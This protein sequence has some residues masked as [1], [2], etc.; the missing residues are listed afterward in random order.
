MATRPSKRF[1]SCKLRVRSI[2]TSGKKITKNIALKASNHISNELKST[3]V[4]SSA[5]ERHN[6]YEF[7]EGEGYCDEEHT[8]ATN[9]QNRREKEFQG[10]QTI[11]ESLLNGR[12]VEEVFL[13][14]EKG[15]EC[16]VIGVE[17]R[18]NECAHEKYFCKGCADSTHET[19]NYFHVLERFKDGYTLPYFP[20]HSILAARHQ[21][22]CHSAQARN[23]ICIDQYGRQHQK[24]I[25]FFECEK[26]SITLIRLKLWPGSATRPSLAFHFKMMEL[27]ETLLLECHV[28]LRKFCDA[29]KIWTKCS[30]L[31]LWIKN[32]YSTLNSNSFDEFRYH[33]HLLR[34][35]YPLVN[36]HVPGGY[37][38]PL[39]PKPDEAGTLIESM[40]AYF[41]LVR[42]KTSG[43]VQFLSR[44]N[45][46]LFHNQEEVDSFVDNYT[47]SAEQAK[48]PF[49]VKDCHEF[50]AGEVND[51]IRSKGRNKLFDEK[52]VFGCVCRHD[53]PKGFMNIKHGERIGYSVFSVKHQLSNSNENTTIKIMYDIACTLKAHLMKNGKHDFVKRADYSIPVFHCYGHKSLCQIQFNPRRK[54]GYGLTDGEGV[55]RLWSF[56]RGFS[57]MTK[58]MSS[59]R[60]LDILTD[61]LLHYSSRRLEQFDTWMKEE[62]Q[63]I[64]EKN[65]KR[66]LP[67]TWQQK[68]VES[69][70][71]LY[72]L[73]MQIACIQ[74]VD[75]GHFADIVKK[76]KKVTK[77][78]ENIE[79]R[80]KV[81]KRWKPGE[82]E[83][84]TA[85]LSLELKRNES[86]YMI[87][88]NHVN[89]SYYCYILKYI[90]SALCKMPYLYMH[91]YVNHNNRKSLR[92]GRGQPTDHRQRTGH[93]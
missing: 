67:L 14:E 70:L 90:I 20:N 58:E 45:S 62:E 88:H 69:L 38:C 56:L 83:F 17:F 54:K 18:C 50:K 44:H 80:K 10:W 22:S 8:Y 86:C 6:L 27:A 28:S 64:N 59:G 7:D 29:L 57:G 9:Y 5:I 32:M 60:R 66:A 37:L 61:A 47:S 72:Q 65:S 84:N 21:K 75:H 79:R 39:C 55:E 4:S 53:Y 46:I 92:I 26:D 41:G 52:G 71:Q 23:V 89:Y 76:T 81:A 11:R 78:V 87:I 36:Q 2:S 25:L 31:P 68:Y 13:N 16:G 1:K 42:K 93:G 35:G 82:R 15:S 51:M 73:R 3:N 40:D 34:N 30:S 19:S 49:I 77:Q 43:K 12:I 74:E 24:Q 91:V 33:R 48:T 63:L 85:A